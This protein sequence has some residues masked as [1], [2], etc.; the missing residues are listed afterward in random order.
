MYERLNAA[1][2]NVHDN[3]VSIKS[4]SLEHEVA[5]STLYGFRQAPPAGRE[6][7]GSKGGRASKLTKETEEAL[8]EWVTASNKQGNGEGIKEMAR[9]LN[10]LFDEKQITLVGRIICLLQNSYGVSERNTTLC[11]RSPAP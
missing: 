10:D 2:N 6:R 7:M 8:V 9:K 3:G 11:R 5:L 1:L 4:A